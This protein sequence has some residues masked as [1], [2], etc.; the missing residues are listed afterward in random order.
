MSAEHEPITEV[1]GQSPVGSKGRGSGGKATLKLKAF[2]DFLCPKE[3]EHLVPFE[4]FHGGF[5]SGPM[6]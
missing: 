5:Q 2:L 4:Q 1:W 6:E 3:V